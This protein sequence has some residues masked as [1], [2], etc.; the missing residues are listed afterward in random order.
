[1]KKILNNFVEHLYQSMESKDTRRLMLREQVKK[2]FRTLCYGKEQEYR[3]EF[4]IKKIKLL[5]AF[6]LIAGG[7][8]LAYIVN[9]LLPSYLQDGNKIR[10]NDYGG[11]RSMYQ[12]G[13]AADGEKRYI[14]V[15]VNDKKYTSGEIKS[16]YQK[17]LPELEKK[18]LGKNS[19]F[20]HVDQDLNYISSLKG[21]PFQIR[22]ENMDY[23]LIQADGALIQKNLTEEG[24]S[25]SIFAILSYEDFQAEYQVNLKL[26]MQRKAP[27]ENMAENIMTQIAENEE[28]GKENDFLVLPEEADGKK[29]LW[30][31]KKDAAMLLLSVLVIAAGGSTFFLQDYELHKKIVLR[32][33]QMRQDYADIVSQL[34]VYMS[35]GM[36]CRLAWEKIT[37]QY[38]QNKKVFEHYAY[39]EMLI[40]MREMQGGI[41]EHMAYERFG[42]RCQLQ[43]YMKF[44]ALLLQNLRKGSISL[45]KSLQDEAQKAFEDK[46]RD[47]RR[48]GEEA[49]TRLLIPMM[50][51]LCMVMLI[52]LLPVI[53]N[54]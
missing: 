24:N 21:F 54:L 37:I 1:M 25:T 34:T 33:R 13:Y 32:E 23:D 9:L 8:F 6:M 29:I 45:T 46:K 22:W 53:I 5:L 39:E 30:Y 40:T 31:E 48:M 44:S 7:C 35:A 20:E 15:S 26:F 14:E 50:L 27:E 12:L 16:L 36:T 2:D 49:S 10:R 41:S 3:K 42:C 51:Q 52:I 38:E 11:G 47:A 43:E 4:Y 19:S 18:V 17:A 28:K